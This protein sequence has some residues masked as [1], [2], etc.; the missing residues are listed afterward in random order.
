MLLSRLRQE[1]TLHALT[2]ERRV[3]DF[4]P[5]EVHGPRERELGGVHVNS[6]PDFP[7]ALFFSL[8]CVKRPRQISLEPRNG[9]LV[10]IVVL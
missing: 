10:Y 8:D 7:L 9:P 4:L 3:R 5:A 6:D 1:E 2:S